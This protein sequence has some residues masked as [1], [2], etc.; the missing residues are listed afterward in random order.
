MVIAIGLIWQAKS[1][2]K[3]NYGSYVDQKTLNGILLWNIQE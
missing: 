1:A 3:I 2:K